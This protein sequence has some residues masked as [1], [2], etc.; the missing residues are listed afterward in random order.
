LHV[1]PGTVVPKNHSEI[2][3]G[4]SGDLPMEVPDRMM[5]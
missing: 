3:M 5:G 4:S 1:S 2:P